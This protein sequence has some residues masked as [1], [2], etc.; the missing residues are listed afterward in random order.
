MGKFTQKLNVKLSK[1]FSSYK[2]ELYQT[3]FTSP[4]WRNVEMADEF[5]GFLKSGNA[6]YR[7][8]FFRQLKTFWQIFWQSY[9]VSRKHHGFWELLF[10]EYMMMNIFIGINVTVEFVLKGTLSLFLSIG[11]K[12][13]N[14]T[15]FQQYTAE[16]YE[17]YANFIHKVPFFNFKYKSSISPL[18]QHFKNSPNK[19]LADYLTFFMVMTE[20]TARMVISFPVAWWYNQPQNVASEQIQ[21]IIKS[22]RKFSDIKAR[23]PALEKI[24]EKYQKS[25]ASSD[26]YYHVTVPRYGAFQQTVQA[27]VSQEIKI[28]RI[29]GQKVIQFKIQANTEQLNELPQKKLLFSY[30]DHIDTT[31]QYVALDVQCKE[32]NQTVKDLDSKKIPIKLIHD[33]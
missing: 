6:F 33:F 13:Q 4:E 8:P 14:Q 11:M 15:E 31:K 24:G 26:N 23:V 20:W 3:Y 7:F 28:Q 27:L 25:E 16:L 17:S 2:R 32:L 29:A 10:S 18:W 30:H 1:T 5:A 9:Q 21:L 12:K 22:K 19:T